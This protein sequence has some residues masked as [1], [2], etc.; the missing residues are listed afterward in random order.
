ML[1][2][3]WQVVAGEESK[4]IEDQHQREMRVLEAY[5]PRISSIPPKSESS[6][7]L[8][9]IIFLVSMIYFLLRMFSPMIAA[10]NAALL[11]QWILK[12]PIALIVKL[13]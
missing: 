7:A 4:E 2:L 10:L 6:L 9:I 8:F 11:F 1:N 3:T 5:Y 12:I 13:F